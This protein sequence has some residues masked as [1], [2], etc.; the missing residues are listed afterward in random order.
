[1]AMMI[2]LYKNEKFNVENVK[3]GISNFK[4]GILFLFL[5]FVQLVLGTMRT[6]ILMQFKNEEDV[7]FSNLLAITWGSLFINCVAPSTLFGDVFRMKELMSVDSAT[8]KDNT[9]YASVFSKIFSTIALVFI[10][11]TARV[12][13]DPFPET[14]SGMMN[15]LYVVAAVLVGGY[16][17]RNWLI[18]LM[19]PFFNKFYDLSKREFYIKRLD[20]FRDYN[21]NLLTGKTVF[22][23]TGLSVLMQILNTLSFI[24]IIYI[25]NPDV[26]SNLLELMIVIPVGIFVMLIPVSFSGLGVGHI[27]FSKL[28]ALFGM[29]YGADVFTIYFAFSYLFNLLGVAPFLILFSRKEQVA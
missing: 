12:F 27:A 13:M 15:V 20:A 25:L 4:I 21:S 26:V 22:M 18:K 1:M 28:L 6:R 3:L 16:L 10:S 17:I 2:W 23:A 19:L 8:T 5:T 7:T 9:I 24:L 11:I 29:E 14:L